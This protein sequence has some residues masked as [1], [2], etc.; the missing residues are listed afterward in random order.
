MFLQ[1]RSMSGEDLW[2]SPL[3]RVSL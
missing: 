2:D 1:N 3:A